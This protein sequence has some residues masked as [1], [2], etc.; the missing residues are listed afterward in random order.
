MNNILLFLE[1]IGIGTNFDLAIISVALFG[2]LALYFGRIIGDVQIE[3]H[4]K[5]SYQIKG[6]LFLIG[7]V[8]LP[9]LVVYFLFMYFPSPFLWLDSR[10]GFTV[11][12]GIEIIFLMIYYTTSWI[13]NVLKF[14]LLYSERFEERFDQGIK[15]L[16]I[17]NEKLEIARE[18]LGCNFI[19]F[20]RL[21]LLTTK[22]IFERS[23]V[24]F[25]SSMVIGALVVYS[26]RFG[27]IRLSISLII[28]FMTYSVIAL[29]KG[30]SD[31][32]YPPAIVTLDDGR[33]IY[34]KITSFGDYV[35]VWQGDEKY[36]L[37][38]NNISDIQESKWKDEKPYS[39]EDAD[40][41]AD[42][43]GMHGSFNK[44]IRSDDTEDNIDRLQTDMRRWLENEN[45]DEF[46]GEGIDVAIVYTYE[47]EGRC[48]DLD[49]LVKP[50][51][52]TL[53]KQN[54]EE[55]YLVEDDSQI[56]TI[57][58]KKNKVDEMLQSDVK[59]DETEEGNI[60][61]AH[62]YITVSF[63]EHSRKPMK[64]VNKQRI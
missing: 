38:K 27:V 45:F 12:I 20:F 42:S 1:D 13:G 46:R 9:M 5:K 57:L 4:D 41:L 32:Y 58:S 63:R 17:S 62:G 60:R 14:D 33:R 35:N 26:F 28:S 23:L 61:K 53:D 43:V 36:H 50:I 10:I 18:T 6:V 31:S 44:V 34:G 39:E 21:T 3:K 8:I 51:I 55:P 54:E 59:V 49:N 24:R 11:V 64:L 29:T 16:S 30:Y 25:F 15:K 48:L 22:R 7:E 52:S 47:D 40:V 56:K 19:E 2:G 37:N